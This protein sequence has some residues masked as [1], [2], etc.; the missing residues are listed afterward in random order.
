MIRRP[1]SILSVLLLGCALGCGGGGKSAP[2]PAGMPPPAGGGGQ[3]SGTNQFV[4]IA[5]S[6]SGNISGFMLNGD[7]TV[8]PLPRSPFVA[9]S[10]SVTADAKG[11]VLF[12]DDGHSMATLSVGSDG[13]LSPTSSVA[14]PFIYPVMTNPAGTN[15]YASTASIGGTF[16]FGYQVF[17]VVAGGALQA[18]TQVTN[19]AP[20]RLGF[21]P[22]G[23]FAY[24]GQEFHTNAAILAF[25]VDASGNL[26]PIATNPPLPT[27]SQGNTA[28]P[29]DVA[30]SPNGQFLE[31]SLT[32][33]VNTGE[34]WIAVY[35]IDPATGVLTQVSGSPFSIGSVPD[36][37]TFDSVGQWLITAQANGADVY[38]F[39]SSGSVAHAA[40]PFGGTPLNR[41]VMSPSGEFVLALSTDHNQFFIFNLTQPTGALHQTA[42]SP[43]IVGSKPDDIAVLQK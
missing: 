3:A 14:G 39:S 4:Y 7:G 30:V 2:G 6:G 11:D 35:S 37:I 5:N 34:N 29:T 41:V 1:A 13:S 18:T 40:E 10:L 17:N 23:R 38:S 27:D 12:S 8:A 28:A 21:T 36:D 42:S 25:A 33:I 15:A 20:D 32:S 19:P 9:P 24:A 22:D 16:N 31:V 26:S 43:Q